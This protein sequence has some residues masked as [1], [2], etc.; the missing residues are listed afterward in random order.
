MVK[1]VVLIPTAGMRERFEKVVSRLVIPEDVMMIEQRFIF[2]TPQSLADNKD[3]DILVAR[4]MTYDYLHSLFPDK[5]M[6]RI[7]LT[8]FDIFDALIRARDNFHPKK[9]G[10]CL[11][12]E[13]I[14]SLRNLE[15]LCQA[16]IDLYDVWDERSTNEAIRKGIELGTDVFVGAGTICGLCDKA[17]VP[18][19]HIETKDEAIETAL[20]SAVS[21]ARTINME[22]TRSSLFH[23][24]LNNSEEAMIAISEDGKV[25]AVNNQTYRTFQLSTTERV[26]GQPVEK[27]YRKFNWRKAGREAGDSAELIEFKGKKFYVEYQKI[28]DDS[29][30]S[31]MLIAVRSTE[32]IQETESKIRQSLTDQGLTAKYTFEDIKGISQGMRDNV[33][34]ARRYSHVDSN[35]LIMGE[36]GTG[37]ELFAHSI[38]QESSRSGEP[39]VALN[40]AALPENL[41]ESE[42]FGYEPGAF[43]GASKNGK[44]GLF[45]LAH[46]GTIFLDEIGELPISLQAK[47]LR[48][49]QEKEIRRVGSDRVKPIDVRVISATN[50]NIEK[51]IEEG[52]FRSDLYYRINLLDLV[53][54]PLRERKEDVQEL[55]DFYLTQFACEMKRRIP[56]VSKGAARM[57]MEYDWPGNVRELR[58]ICEKLIVLS[59]TAEIGEE[60]LMQL[61]IFKDY[62]KRISKKQEK[63]DNYD[64]IYE[65]LQPRR[66][67]QDIARE[68]GVSR[69]TLWRMAKKQE[70]LNHLGE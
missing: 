58:N 70:K 41:L 24:I 21:A 29:A 43:S 5:Y 15:E 56:R 59:D 3:A 14:G 40:C 52:Q 47:L 51:Q 49:L 28:I 13:E 1:I 20:R 17:G 4:G 32:K 66:K 57:L 7:R 69:T 39:F 34:M 44:V 25:L 50:I 12:N 42:L 68:L 60:E 65:Q 64:E 37:K 36:T 23:T 9:I 27:V 26:E 54:P 16:S 6:V 61:K 18:R 62:Q 19:V 30:G 63:K 11:H 8:S 33:R 35:V 38:H 31:G 48:V 10:L 45:E 67:K 46:R 22:R 53:I 2:G 55:V